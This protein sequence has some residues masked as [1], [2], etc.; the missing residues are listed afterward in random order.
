MKVRFSVLLAVLALT[1]VCA[2]PVHRRSP[3]S[4]GQGAGNPNSESGDRRVNFLSDENSDIDSADT[5]SGLSI[6]TPDAPDQQPQE[7]ADDTPGEVREIMAQ[8]VDFTDVP[9]DADE[10]SASPAPATS[11][12][13]PD[14]PTTP[15]QQSDS[16]LTEMEP[17]AEMDPQNSASQGEAPEQDTGVNHSD[18]DGNSIQLMVV[19]ASSDHPAEA[20]VEESVG[21][22]DRNQNL[23]DLNPLAEPGLGDQNGNDGKPHL[24][25]LTETS[26]TNSDSNPTSTT[27]EEADTAAIFAAEPAPSPSP[28]VKWDDS[29]VSNFDS[30]LDSLDTKVGDVSDATIHRRPDKGRNGGNQG[31]QQHNQRRQFSSDVPTPFPSGAQSTSQSGD[32]LWCVMSSSQENGIICQS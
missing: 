20:P 30:M 23:I 15:E 21:Q 11:A 13:G 12:E 27:P 7:P 24:I 16:N 3:A 14:A 26:D 1:V 2:Q 28:E 4:G 22:S 18:D 10:M 25:E 5:S 32:N 17:T 19:P 8:D 6:N 9:A 29:S 31:R